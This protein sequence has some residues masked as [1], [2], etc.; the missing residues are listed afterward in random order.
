MA[1]FLELDA[2]STDF[3]MLDLVLDRDEII[4]QSD[5]EEEYANIFSLSMDGEGGNQWEWMDL[6][7][8]EL[9]LLHHSNRYFPID[10][11]IDEP[12]SL[13]VVVHSEN[14]LLGFS[15]SEPILTDQLSENVEK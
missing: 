10:F 6:W 12:S 1:D 9:P 7:F 2:T 14:S 8:T 5:I 3:L 15:F 13:S 4:H 11:D